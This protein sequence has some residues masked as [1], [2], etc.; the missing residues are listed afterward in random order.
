[1]VSEAAKEKQVDLFGNEVK[2]PKEKIIRCTI[3]ELLQWCNDNDFVGK[4]EEEVKMVLVV[5]GSGYYKSKDID[6]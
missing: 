2:P 5:C 3:Q 4:F 1:M 6:K